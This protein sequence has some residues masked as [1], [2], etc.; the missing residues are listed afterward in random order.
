MNMGKKHGQTLDNYLKSR[1]SVEANSQ[2]WIWSLA[3]DK[4]GYGVAHVGRKNIRAHRVSYEAFIE[5]IPEGMGVLHKCDNPPCCNP[6]HLFLGTNQDNMDDMVIKGRKPRKSHCP[7][8]HPYAEP[9]LI[10]ESDGSQKCKICKKR[11]ENLRYHEK[12][13]SH[14]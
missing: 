2:C 11:R 6:Q 8:G 10:I 1:V 14:D 4:D 7:Q 5:Q 12:K 9:N 3:R 13:K